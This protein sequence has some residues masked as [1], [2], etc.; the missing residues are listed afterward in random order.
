MIFLVEFGLRVFA[1][2]AIRESCVDVQSDVA[3]H[4]AVRSLEPD[5]CLFNKKS[6][7]ILLLLLLSAAA[8]AP[9]VGLAG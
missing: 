6:P 5:E 1:A 7:T 2:A 8:A 4:S 3:V 9:A